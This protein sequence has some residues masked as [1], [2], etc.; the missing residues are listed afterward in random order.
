MWT[1]EENFLPENQQYRSLH[2]D[3]ADITSAYR[4]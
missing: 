2:F 3:R 4:Y 1:T